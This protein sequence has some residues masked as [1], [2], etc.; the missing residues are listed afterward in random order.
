[1]LTMAIQL[2]LKLSRQRFEEA[3]RLAAGTT[4]LPLEWIERT[5]RLLAGKYNTFVPM[6]G[7]ALL[8]KATDPR[9]DPFSIQ[10]ASRGDGP[11]NAYN[12]RD[13]AKRVFVPEC[14]SR[15]IQ[16]RTGGAEPLNAHPFYKQQ[17]VTRQLKAKW[18]REVEYL[19]DCLDAAEPLTEKQAL[20][21]LAGTI[22]VLLEAPRPLELELA[23]RPQDLL[24]LLQTTNA[25]ITDDS[26]GGK[27]GQ[28]FVTACLDLVFQDVRT[29]RVNDPSRRTPGDIEIGKPRALTLAAEVKQR[30]FSPSEIVQFVKRCQKR[31][32]RRALI[33]ALDPAQ[34]PLPL[35]ELRRIAW[36][37]HGVHLTVMR[38][39]RELLELALTMSD[40][41]LQESL[42][43]F[44]RL[45]LNRLIEIG[46]SAAGVGAWAA[47]FQTK[48]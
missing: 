16:L 6:L 33:V 11:A 46:V 38:N 32:I 34:P 4:A 28:A 37:E 44:P 26:E 2:D 40:R 35:D 5:R 8:G 3:Y 22:R 48:Q 45:A 31:D 20:D 15:R 18:P 7:T 24:A 23:E 30:P 13:L 25:F 12:A 29:K 36:Q 21:A 39:I 1:V 10:A 41:S 42:S 47:R 19:C 43:S 27:R 17:R 9:V 14:E